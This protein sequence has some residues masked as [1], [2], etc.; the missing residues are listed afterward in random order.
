MALSH[1][2]GAPA[3]VT[4][5]FKSGYLRTLGSASKLEALVVL[6]QNNESRLTGHRVV[7]DHICLLDVSRH[8]A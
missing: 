2:E 8:V 3:W 5:R 7:S 1:S 4:I 6:H